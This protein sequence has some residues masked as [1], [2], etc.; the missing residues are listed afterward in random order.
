MGAIETIRESS[1]AVMLFAAIS[2]MSP[3]IA[4]AQVTSMNQSIIAATERSSELAIANEMVRSLELEV[5]KVRGEYHPQIRLDTTYSELIQV[6]ANSFTAPERFFILKPD[7]VIPLY[8]GGRRKTKLEAAQIETETGKQTVAKG[9]AGL[10]VDVAVLYADTIRDMANFDLASGQVNLLE[11]TYNAS[12]RRQSLGDLTLTDVAQAQ[13]RLLLARS[14]LQRATANLH[15]TKE[16]FR[17]LVG[18]TPQTLSPPPKLPALPGDVI[19]ALK[20]A[21]EYNLSIIEARGSAQAA[22]K[23]YEFVK[24][25]RRPELNAYIDASYS[26]YFGTLGGPISNGFEQ[27]ETNLGVGVRLTVPIYNGG[28][29]KADRAIANSGSNIARLRVSGLEL[30]VE[31][32]L[33]TLYK[34]IEMSEGRVGYAVLAIEAAKLSL[35]GVEAEE[36]VGNRTV[37]DVLN[38]QQELLRAQVAKAA[39]ERDLYVSKLVTHNTIGSLLIG[40]LGV[41]FNPKLVSLDF[42]EP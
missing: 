12:S 35:R 17:E 7:V 32:Q 19:S 40:P 14:D 42:R 3:S 16:K 25:N 6:S 4:N 21:K 20:L 39:A 33:R 31:R 23:K 28:Q 41:E 9:R 1:L 37:L 30:E 2:L 34:D 8:D 29:L 10:A 13:S 24:R 5:N 15:A 27:S 26:N 11:E 22:E 38:A 18:F 36:S